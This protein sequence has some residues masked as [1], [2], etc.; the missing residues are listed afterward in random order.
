MR[1]SC[2]CAITDSEAVARRCYETL[3]GSEFDRSLAGS[4]APVSVAKERPQHRR[5]SRRKRVLGGA[6][7]ISGVAQAPFVCR[8]GPH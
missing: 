6:G 8:S 2:R 7:W 5:R 3:I 4:T 1:K